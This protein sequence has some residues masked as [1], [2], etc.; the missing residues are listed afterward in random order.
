MVVT[1][2]MLSCKKDYIKGGSTHNADMY[3][4]TLSY[5]VLKQIPGY[6]SVLILFD[7]A[8]LKD[9][10]NTPGT[11]FFPPN[12]SAI[13][14]YLNAR[15]IAL[16]IGNANA[17]F[18]FDS[19]IYCVKNNTRGL[20]DSLGMYFIAT[21]LP[22]SALTN[23][24]AKYATKLNGDTAVISF[25]YVNTNTGLGYSSLVSSIPQVVYYTKMWYPYS[26]LTDAN[27]ASKIPGTV[28]VRTICQTSGIVTKNGVMH[29]LPYNQNLFFYGTKK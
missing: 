23:A 7:S 27:P 8:G 5:D 6:D 28:G 22:Y 13:I 25:E 2:F 26:S 17:K 19:L 3:K 10:I 11:T 15:T 16:Q 9:M 24:G 14:N 21:A 20:R 29:T 18:G 12:N 4:N 1:T